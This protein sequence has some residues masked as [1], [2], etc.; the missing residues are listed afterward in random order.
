MSPNGQT[1]QMQLVLQV[2]QRRTVPTGA[3]PQAQG[4]QTSQDTHMPILRQELYAGNVFEQAYAK[5]RGED[6]QATTDYDARSE[7]S[8]SFGSSVLAQSIPR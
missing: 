2:F 1:L 6:G 4:E 8:R 7:P 3:H 5:A